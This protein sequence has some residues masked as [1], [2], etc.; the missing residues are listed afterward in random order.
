MLWSG[1]RYSGRVVRRVQC[2][3]PHVV[4]FPL[5]R[6]WLVIPRHHEPCREER[7]EVN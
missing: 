5:R 3:L 4:S 2:P 7:Y 6:V 1:F